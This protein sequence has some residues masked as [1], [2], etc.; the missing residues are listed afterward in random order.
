MKRPPKREAW[1][2][3]KEAATPPTP[4]RPT[5]KPGLA[6]T[7][8]LATIKRRA[9]AAGFRHK[10]PEAQRYLVTAAQNAT[11]GARRVPGEPADLREGERG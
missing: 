1:V 6:H 10:L 11:H 3:G 8:T 7:E 2:S 5:P 9:T 4:S